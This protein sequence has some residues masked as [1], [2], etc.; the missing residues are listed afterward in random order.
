MNLSLRRRQGNH[1]P[2]DPRLATNALS[3]SG[4]EDRKN[5]M[6]MMVPKGGEVSGVRGRFEEFK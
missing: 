2:N 1:V 5:T 4:A 3:N 6:S